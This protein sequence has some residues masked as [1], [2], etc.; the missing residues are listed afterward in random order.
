MGAGRIL[1]AGSGWAGALLVTLA[2]LRTHL[3][4]CTEPPKRF[5]FQF[6]GDCHFTNG[7][8]RVRLLARWIYNQQ[9]FVHFDSDLGLFVADTEL[10]RSWAEG[11]NKDQAFLA[12]KRAEVDTYCRNNYR[13]DTP[14]TIDRRVQPKVKV[15]P[16][17]SGSGPHS[18]LL[19]CSVTRFYPGGIEIKWLKN[20]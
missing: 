20:G 18:H 7:T 11:W 17:K 10:G 2:M 1:G 9:Q 5:V 4:H 12:Q 16:M 19:V 6:K 13:V 14:F 3:A 15:S 8:E